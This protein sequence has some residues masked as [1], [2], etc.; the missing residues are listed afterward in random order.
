MPKHLTKINIAVCIVCLFQLIIGCGDKTEP[1][2]KAAA[3]SKKIVAKKSESVP[4]TVQAPAVDAAI[5]P[6][7]V[8][9]LK[10]DASATKINGK[11]EKPAVSS[12][13]PTEPV[14][15]GTLPA[16]E[17]KPGFAGKADKQKPDISP[18]KVESTA[19]PLAGQ[20]VASVSSA[21][22]EMAKIQP[23]EIISYNPEGKIDPFAP[24]FKEEAASASEKGKKG[25]VSR[26]PLEMIDLD[27][28]KLVAIM[29]AKGGN[30]ALVEEASG[31]GYIVAKGTYMGI[32][33]GRVVKILKDSII[34]EE[35]VENIVGKRTIQE[36][37]LKLQKPLGEE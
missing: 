4:A 5:Q 11:T 22:A 19:P 27:Q 14:A 33:S 29:R 21:P 13:P 31:K 1:S 25:R 30:K 35:E 15:K 16:D 34:I 23:E 37:E 8:K 28:L 10:T 2:Q 32:N 20:A 12:Q 7:E 3:V 36:R 24:L 18:A 9:E 6:A 26:T 17:G